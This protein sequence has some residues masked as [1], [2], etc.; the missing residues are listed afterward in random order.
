QR[1]CIFPFS[2][3]THHVVN[4]P[5][6]CED[7]SVHDNLSYSA[8]FDYEL[9]GDFAEAGYDFDSSDTL[10][11]FDD[12]QQWIPDPFEDSSESEFV[13]LNYKDDN[14]ENQATKQAADAT[15][16]TPET[17][18]TPHLSGNIDP[19]SLTTEQAK[20]LLLS[21]PSQSRVDR[22]RG[23]VRATENRRPIPKKIKR[24]IRP[25]RSF[26]FCNV[27]IH[28]CQ[29]D[30]IISSK[31]SKLPSPKPGIQSTSQECLRN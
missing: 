1:Q 10:N 16:T 11:F 8:D 29:F 4:K 6:T 17:P 2:E 12:F 25:N 22:R 20:E 18:T 26:F 13:A 24:N 7:F 9:D 28:T 23:K 14:N 27:H 5:L 15:P 21:H 19:F 3:S 31:L 30:I